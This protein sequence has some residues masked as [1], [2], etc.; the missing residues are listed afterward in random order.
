MGKEKE[1]GVRLVTRIGQ[2]SLCVKEEMFVGALLV[3]QKAETG[4]INLK[5]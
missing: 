2:I 5:I 3:L 1:E 4:T